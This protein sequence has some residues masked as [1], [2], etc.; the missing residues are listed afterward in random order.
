MRSSNLP[1]FPFQIFARASA[2]QRAGGSIA[3]CEKRAHIAPNRCGAAAENMP[4]ICSKI[5]RV[6][7]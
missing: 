6:K 1:L 3:V 4:A 7:L 5:E 2:L